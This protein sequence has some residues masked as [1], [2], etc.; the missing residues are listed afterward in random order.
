MANILR[1]VKKKR[2]IID[3]NNEPAF[4]LLKKKLKKE[5]PESKQVKEPTE[6]LITLYL[7]L[8]LNQNVFSV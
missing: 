7:A 6:I 4:H 3:F 2:W 1:A 8:T 5:I